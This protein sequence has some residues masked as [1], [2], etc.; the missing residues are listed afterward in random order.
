MPTSRITKFNSS[1][2]EVT[3]L[4]FTTTG[5]S[6]RALFYLNSTNELVTGGFGIREPNNTLNT[7]IVPTPFTDSGVVEGHP[8]VQYGAYKEY[9]YGTNKYN[10]FTKTDL[11]ATS[12]TPSFIVNSVGYVL[13]HVNHTLVQSNYS[14]G[15]T[16]NTYNWS[17]LWSITLGGGDTVNNNAFMQDLVTDGT[18]GYGFIT[19]KN[20]STYTNHLIKFNIANPT[21]SPLTATLSTSNDP[22]DALVYNTGSGCLLVHSAYNFNLY[23][24][25]TSDLTSVAN[26]TPIYNFAPGLLGNYFWTNN[27]S[28]AS[29]LHKRDCDTATFGNSL[30]NVEVP[31]PTGGSIV[32]EMSAGFI[33]STTEKVVGYLTFKLSVD[34]DLTI[35]PLTFGNFCSN[36]NRLVTFEASGGLAPYT[37]TLDNVLSVLPPEATFTDNTDGTATFEGTAPFTPGNYRLKF[38]LSDDNSDIVTIDQS[39]E[40]YAAPEL[41]DTSPFTATANEIYSHFITHTG[42]SLFEIIAGLLPPGLTLDSGTGEISGTPTVVGQWTFTVRLKSA[43]GC[44]DIKQYTI[45]VAEGGDL[46][47]T[48]SSLP[49][50][51]T[52]AYYSQ[53]LTATGGTTPYVWELSSGAL[54]TGMF[55]E[56]T[57]GEVHGTCGT[58]GTYNFT[59]TVTDSTIPNPYTDSAALSI[60]VSGAIFTGLD[61]Y[62]LVLGRPSTTVLTTNLNQTDVTWYILDGQLP[63]GLSLYYDDVHLFAWIITG[64]PI[65][66]GTFQPTLDL[67]TNSSGCVGTIPFY[68]IV[69]GPPDIITESLPSG[70]LG[71]AYSAYVVAEGGKPFVSNGVSYYIWSTLSGVAG[72]LPPGL[73]INSTTGEISGIPT[74][75]GTFSF[76]VYVSDSNNLSDQKAFTITIT[77]GGDEEPPDGGPDNGGPEGDNPSYLRTRL[78]S[79]K[80]VPVV[81]EDDFHQKYMIEYVPSTLKRE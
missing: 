79:V 71:V 53:T 9:L 42:G 5:N 18:N 23:K 59:V 2:S 56:P 36:V 30:A 16:T 73:S 65:I 50:C 11:G 25:L 28:P 39:F 62:E 46:S 6:V 21:S 35:T 77:S 51:C 31:F 49:G 37:Y 60:V 27:G 64:T 34:T 57:T 38:D 47:I 41:T 29:Y 22:L 55:L 54:P 48:T 68:Y 43:A 13:D 33:T 19:I 58:A 12:Y 20:G 75:V 8:Y 52:Y 66:A 4:E 17:D 7:T 70:R 69:Y 78:A 45:I 24:V 80:S 81:V 72:N 44:K 63:N 26:A 32:Y 3:N 14:T 74:Q 15:S 40:I 10:V 67:L 61:T 1:P 76:T